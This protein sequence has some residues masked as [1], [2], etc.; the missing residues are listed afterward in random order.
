MITVENTLLCS[1]YY[2]APH[3]RH[4]PDTWHDLWYENLRKYL[5]PLPEILVMANG[6]CVPPVNTGIRKV[7]LSHPGGHVGELL[8][9]T[10]PYRHCGWSTIMLSMAMIAYA[11]HKNYIYAESDMLAF[12]PWFEQ[13][14]E[15]LGDGNAVIGQPLQGPVYMPCSNSLFMV[16]HS[17]IPEFVSRYLALPDENVPE[18]IPEIKM[19]RMMEADPKSFRTLSFGYDRQRPIRFEDRVFYAQKFTAEE[20]SELKQRG[21]L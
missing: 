10:R 11:E 8:N 18:W 16:R 17:F 2:R 9:G 7:F 3:E 13:M 6:G 12:G 15:D 4:T 19:F 21:L 1:G 20:M 5:N 14:I